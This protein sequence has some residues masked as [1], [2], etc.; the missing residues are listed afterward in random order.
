MINL[1]SYNLPQKKKQLL[2]ELISFIESTYLTK[3]EQKSKKDGSCTIFFRKSG[4]SLCYID[5]R[6][7]EVTVVLVLGSA[8][9]EEVKTLSLSPETEKQIKTTKL[10]H[11]GKWLF[12]KLDKKG[13]VEDIQKLLLLKKSPPK[14][15]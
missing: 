12:F 10:L 14:R 7:K 8:L 11:D 4:K 9:S 13:E 6:E 1:R 3:G 5:V 2:E 15:T